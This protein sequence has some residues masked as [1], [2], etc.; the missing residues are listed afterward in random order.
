MITYSGWHDL[1]SIVVP[2]LGFPFF[3]LYL[4]ISKIRG[5]SE[6]SNL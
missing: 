4:Q 5:R 3:K 2:I 1:D 6:L